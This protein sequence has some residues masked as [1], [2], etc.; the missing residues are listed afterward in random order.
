MEYF[1]ASV[2]GKMEV[3]TKHFNDD[4]LQ[5]ELFGGVL[6]SLQTGKN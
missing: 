4:T 6:S 2:L 5:R 1:I 3:D